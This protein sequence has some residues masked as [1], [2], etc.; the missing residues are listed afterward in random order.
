MLRRN[1]HRP[2]PL[3]HAQARFAIPMRTRSDTN[4]NS[5]P[6]RVVNCM[7][8]VRL[9]RIITRRLRVSVAPISRQNGIVGE[10]GLGGQGTG[11]EMPGRFLNCPIRIIVFQKRG[12]RPDRAEKLGRECLLILLARCA[13]IAAGEPRAAGSL[14]QQIVAI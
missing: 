7:S 6:Q 14:R 13:E 3:G 12:E 2:G 11:T 9:D 8:A 4:T 5:P 1:H 10:Q